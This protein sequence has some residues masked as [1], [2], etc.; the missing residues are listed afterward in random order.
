[1]NAAP[2]KMALGFLAAW[3]TVVLFAVLLT[4]VFSFLGA[5]F[6]AAL[7]GMMFGSVRLPLW[8]AT[9]FSLTFPAVLVSILRTGGAELL[10]GQVLLLALVCLATFWLTYVLVRA[11]IWYER[12][13]DP[14]RAGGAVN[15]LSHTSALPVHSLEEASPTNPVVS[16][17]ARFWRELSLQLLQGKWSCVSVDGESRREHKLMEIEREELRLSV[18]DFDGKVRFISKAEV[19][20]ADSQ[21]RLLTV[22]PFVDQRCDDTLV[23]I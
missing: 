23:S 9:T 16:T 7:A 11:L 3:A 12:K 5:I 18:S 6:C 4:L 21:P 22:S 19:K 13:P 17:P 15:S 14:T 20:L 2:L 8:Q 1:M 10:A